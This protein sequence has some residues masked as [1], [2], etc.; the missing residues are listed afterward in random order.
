MAVRYDRWVRAPV[1]PPNLQTLDT[2]IHAQKV[3]KGKNQKKIATTITRY[4]MN[5]K[6]EHQ[7]RKGWFIE[8]KEIGPKWDKKL[9]GLTFPCQI[10]FL[11]GNGPYRFYCHALR[12]VKFWEMEEWVQEFFR[13]QSTPKKDY[14]A[15][16]CG[17]EKLPRI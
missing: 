6:L 8:Y 4:A 9:S 2:W 13:R 14:Y 12:T 15:L 10:V 1:Q 11:V 3:R 17:G 5:K 7:T 16:L